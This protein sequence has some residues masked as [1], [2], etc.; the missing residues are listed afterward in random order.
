M[1]AYSAREFGGRA[2]IQYL[3][4]GGKEPAPPWACSCAR[5]AC[6]PGD[7]RATGGCLREGYPTVRAVG[8][9]IALEARSWCDCRHAS[10]LS[11]GLRDRL[12]LSC[13]P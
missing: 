4:E 8:E 6:R 5:C 1:A 9:A 3:L 12:S 7:E 2:R 10:W 11:L 13:V